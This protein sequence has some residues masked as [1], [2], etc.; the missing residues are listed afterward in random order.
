MRIKKACMNESRSSVLFRKSEAQWA[1]WG[2][3]SNRRSRNWLKPIYPPR[4]QKS[5]YP[6]FVFPSWIT[7]HNFLKRRKIQMFWLSPLCRKKP[8][9]HCFS[10]R[11]SCEAEVSLFTP[12]LSPWCDWRLEQNAKNRAGAFRLSYTAEAPGSARVN[13]YSSGSPQAEDR[14]LTNIALRLDE[15]IS[16][17]FSMLHLQTLNSNC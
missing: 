14:S 17:E 3:L 15:W 12:N 16:L 10:Y 1:K 5:K 9:Q 2:R 4:N 8:V 6:G 7:S 11:S 13:I